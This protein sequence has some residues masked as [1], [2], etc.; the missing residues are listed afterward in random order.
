MLSAATIVMGAIT[1]VWAASEPQVYDFSS[2]S[3]LPAEFRTTGQGS[4]TLED[5]KLKGTAADLSDETTLMLGETTW[6]DV[7]VDVGVSFASAKNPTC[8]FAVIVR[9]GGDDAPGMQFT[10]RHDTARGNGLEIAAKRPD[11]QGWHVLRLARTQSGFRAGESHRVRIEAAGPW[12]CGFLDDNLVIRS[13]RGNEY[14]RAGQVGLRINGAS[15]MIDRIQVA[16]LNAA[17]C[18]T[19]G[20]LRPRPLVVAHRGFS[21]IA[22]ENTLAAYRL[23]IEAGADFAECDVY[24]TRDNI[25]V[26]M[27]DRTLGRTT[28]VSDRMRDLTLAEVRKLDAGKWK[29]PQFEGEGV[30]T[31]VEA[32][33]LTK[34]KLRLVIEI[35]EEAMSPQVVEAIRSTAVD[36]Q[37]L[38]IF[39]FYD[40]AVE[41][42]ARLEPRLP[43]TWLIDD[44]GLDRAAWRAAVTRALEI[45]ATAIGTSLTRVD[46]G[47]VRL[48]HEC[49]LMVFVWTVNEPQDV[50]YLLSIGVDVVITDRPDMALEVIRSRRG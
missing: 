18:A 15:V 37:D 6:Q 44:P 24:L 30:P 45:R 25:P 38:M 1:S 2:M 42:I 40:K 5:G 13:Y 7:A 29:G 50:G 33:E 16:P 31:L 8:W 32:I 17:H 35:K 36:P 49:G 4:W 19:V 46:P 11:G 26:L 41:E 48:A 39:S 20:E 34:G 47:F 9:D 14:N 3:A 28:G 12:V 23:A 43:T 27:H 22:P 21:W 10:V